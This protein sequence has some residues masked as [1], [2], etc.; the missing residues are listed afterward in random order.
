MEL[1]ERFDKRKMPLGKSSER[2]VNVPGE[3]GQ[4][5]H[6]WIM[7]SKGEFLIQ[8]RSATKRLHPNLWS[9][10]GGGTDPGENSLETTI[11]ETKE[12]LGIDINIANL[13]FMLSFKRKDIFLDVWLLK[14][15]IS[16]S[17]LTLQ[18][19][20]VSDAKWVS[21]DEIKQL[22]KTNQTSP[23]LQIYFDMFEKLLEI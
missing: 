13:E 17:E 9:V 21:M 4:A 5:I 19:E 2:Y 22:L 7:N 1:V 3:Y 6:L 12:E 11:R 14:E 10:T 16:I 8:K 18:E 15:D 23:T 20:E